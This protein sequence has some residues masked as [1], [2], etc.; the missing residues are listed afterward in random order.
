M[1]GSVIPNK[2]LTLKK[3]Y[4]NAVHVQGVICEIAG[5][6]NRRINFH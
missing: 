4:L 3:K 1:S 5:F 2:V 6:V